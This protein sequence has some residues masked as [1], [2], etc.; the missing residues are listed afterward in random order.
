MKTFE[1]LSQE[2]DKN[3]KGDEMSG[4]CGNF[5]GKKQLDDEM[6]WTNQ[7]ASRSGGAYKMKVCCWGFC[8][9]PVASRPMS[10]QSGK[11]E[12]LYSGLK[13]KIKNY[14]KMEKFGRFSKKDS[15]LQ[16]NDDDGWDMWVCFDLAVLGLPVALE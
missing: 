12:K 11:E 15:E 16:V 14:S 13:D 4:E 7:F 1:F 6:H 5:D 10:L 9:V 8:E 3:I 2:K